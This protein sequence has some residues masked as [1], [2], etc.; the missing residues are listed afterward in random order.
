MVCLLQRLL[1]LAGILQVAFRGWYVPQRSIHLRG[2][3]GYMTAVGD[4]L[5]VRAWI[6]EEWSAFWTLASG[7]YPLILPSIQGIEHE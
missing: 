4:F 6:C 1:V 3:L 5:T 2:M 7:E